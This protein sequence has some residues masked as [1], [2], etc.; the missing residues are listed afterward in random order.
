MLIV[1]QY[2]E[3]SI[4]DWNNLLADGLFA[5]PFQTSEYF[6][7]ISKIKG[8]DPSVF[9]LSDS[10]KIKVLMV[11]TIMKES[12]FMVFFSRRGIVFGG[13]VISDA[14]KE[15]LSFFLKEAGTRLIGKAI[16]LETRNFFDYS[17]YK[18]SFL[19]SGWSYEP[20]LNV[21]LNLVG[22]TKENLLS[23]FKYNRRR[24]IKQSILNG[25]TYHRCSKEEEVLSVYKIL[26]EIYKENVNLP[27]PSFDFFFEFFKTNIMKV[28][29]VMHGEKIIGGSFCPVLPG[30]GLYTFYYCGLRNYHK[31]IFPTHL[32]VLAALEFAVENKIPVVDFM[33]AGKPDIEYGVRK[34]KLEFGGELVEEGRF[35]K[36]LNPIL[37]ILG[38]FG[39]GIIKAIR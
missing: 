36:V 31:R 4:K 15:E 24:E 32:A 27:L 10:A 18:D 17:F 21:K 37:Y 19:K 11:V 2:N 16:Y 5:S 22:V 3:I 12:G 35:L 39:V 6:N 38:K 9:A 14:T 33:G 13:P 23:L 20:Y 26:Q 28:F 30:K 1:L 25:A 7:L 34:F 8:F 29:V